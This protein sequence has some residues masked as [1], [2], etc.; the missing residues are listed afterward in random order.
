VNLTQW[1]SGVEGVS[2]RTRQ[3]LAA[4]H[5]PRTGIVP[6][7]QQATLEDGDARL[8]HVAAR[9]ACV[10][11]G[12]KYELSW[13]AG[14]GGTSLDAA[15]QAALGEAL[16][17][18]AAS[19][20]DPSRIERIT[21]AELRAAGWPLEATAAFSEAQYQLPGFPFLP[22]GQV[23]WLRGI[24]AQWLGD[25]RPA[26]AP[27]A[28]VL[29]VSVPDSNEPPLGPGLSTGLACGST[30][31]EAI[32]RGICE[33]VERDAVALTWLRGLSPPRL[34]SGWISECAGELLPPRDD[35]RAYDLTSDIDVP[36]VLVVCRGMGRRG[37]IVSVG[38]A[39]HW[40]ARSAVRKAALEAS[41]GRVYIRQL[42]DDAPDWR[43]APDFAN[44]T[45]FSLSARLYSSAPDLA[46]RA[47]SFLDWHPAASPMPRRRQASSGERVLKV[48]VARLEAAGHCGV[49][50]DLTPWGLAAADLHVVRV[51]LP[52]LMPLHGDHRLALLGHPR[53]VHAEDALPRAARK[54]EFDLWPYPHPMP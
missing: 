44:V 48:L 31:R 53:L 54:H 37:E 13:S 41:Q 8:V 49:W 46:D 25:G 38:S 33:V 11:T 29:L 47:L 2:D 40:D 14:G 42:L 27:A 32:V 5:G 52:T 45:E 12:E 26:W 1:P 18:F 19:E 23:E 30:I 10:R 4:L 43:P 28:A 51:C 15:V 34:E 3:M 39:C 24:R 9:T 6:Q 22:A 21:A 7:L 50:V 20:L 35:V 36:V 17:R 16:E